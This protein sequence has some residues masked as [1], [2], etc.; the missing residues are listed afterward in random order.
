MFLGLIG[1]MSYQKRFVRL[2]IGDALVFYTDGVI[3]ARNEKDEL[4]GPIALRCR[5]QPRPTSRAGI[6][7]Q[8]P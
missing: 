6:L 1:N 3:D 5:Y 2:D 7:G 4:Y 8:S